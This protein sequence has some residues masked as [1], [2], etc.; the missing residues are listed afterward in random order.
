MVS[1]TLCLL[2]PVSG[3]PIQSGINNLAANLKY[4]RTLLLENEDNDN[5][6]AI[7][8]TRKS[9]QRSDASKSELSQLS[10]EES[11]KVQL[12]HGCTFVTVVAILMG[13]R[14]LYTSEG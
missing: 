14:D 3:I 13:V 10:T 8:N 4:G 2:C 1:L 12:G 7:I 11:L 9:R 5:D 6:D